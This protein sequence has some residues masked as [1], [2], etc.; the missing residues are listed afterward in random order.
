VD[1]GGWEMPVQYTGIIDEHNTVR[2]ACGLF[3]VSHMGEVAVTGPNALGFLQMVVTN[4]VSRIKDGQ[5]IY[6]PMC[7]ASGTIVD[8]L[9]IYRKAADNF[10]IIVNASNTDKDFAWMHSHSQGFDGV[11]VE[12]KS[13]DY[14]QLAIQGPKAVDVLQGIADI[15]LSAIGYFWF[16]EGKVCG[17]D[18]LIARTGYTGEDGFEI[19]FAPQHAEKVWSALMDAGKPRGIKPIG[20]GARDTLR[21]EACYML[22]GNDID[23]RTTPLEATIGWTVKM[24][25]GDFLGKSAMQSKPPAKKLVGF[26]LLERAI[27]RHGDKVLVGGK[28]AG[29]VTSGTFSPTLKKPL[30]MCYVPPVCAEGDEVQISIHDKL[31]R[32]KLTSTRFYKKPPIN[33]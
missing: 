4:D 31:C 5:A 19:C 17:I 11:T 16:D 14:A 7:Y 32:A 26:E 33:K 29:I 18:S 28:E 13:A 25:K 22:Y 6:S 1:F 20:L 21:L 27:A 8:D 2:S 12:N 24:A 10:F 3:D 9:I 15:N 30:G 23:G